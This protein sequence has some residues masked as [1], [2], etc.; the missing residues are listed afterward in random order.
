M[1]FYNQ[2]TNSVQNSWKTQ[3]TTAVKSCN[4]WRCFGLQTFPNFLRS[5]C[6]PDSCG[7]IVPTALLLI[8]RKTHLS[9]SLALKKPLSSIGSEPMT[10]DAKAKHAI[11]TVGRFGS[12]VCKLC[13]AQRCRNKRDGLHYCHLFSNFIMPF[14]HTSGQNYGANI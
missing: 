6:F 7:N 2:K 14:P 1:R 9:F 10:A 11:Y 3:P 13:L 5:W 8:R 4:D 12:H